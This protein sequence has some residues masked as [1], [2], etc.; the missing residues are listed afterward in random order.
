MPASV[1][2]EIYKTTSKILTPP[3]S[4]G[5][6]V[7]VV[8]YFA[9]I[10]N[11]ATRAVNYNSA[12]AQANLKSPIWIEFPQGYHTPEGDHLQFCSAPTQV[13]LRNSNSHRSFGTRKLTKGL[14]KRGYRQ[15]AYDPCLFLK[16]NILIVVFVDNCV[17]CAPNPGIKTN[18]KFHHLRKDFDLTN[19]GDLSSF[20]GVSI[21]GDPAGTFTFTQE[22]LINKILSDTNLQSC[23]PNHTLA[24]PASFG[25]GFRRRAIQGIMALLLHCWHASFLGQQQLP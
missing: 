24:A 18:K 11:L 17:F 23:S 25:I 14:L 16:G 20:L 10:F 1:S 2:E 19:E 7:R 21:Q 3:L 15:S 6:T 8:L 12:F 9:L 22:G 13:A 4:A 5:S